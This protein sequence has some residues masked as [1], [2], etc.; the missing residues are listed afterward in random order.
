ML[1][2]GI[3]DIDDEIAQLGYIQ[4]LSLIGPGAAT[5]ATGTVS[6]SESGALSIAL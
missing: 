3:D 6:L 2:T 5:T 4:T 1:D